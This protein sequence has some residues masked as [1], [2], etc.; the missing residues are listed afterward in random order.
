M[1]R[2]AVFVWILVIVGIFAF[3]SLFA[4][5]VAD[6]INY[7]AVLLDADG[8]AMAGSKAL[9]RISMLSPEDGKQVY[10]SELHDIKTDESGQFNLVIGTG[11]PLIGKLSAV[12][13]ENRAVWLDVE[14]EDK[15]SRQFRHLGNS[16]LLAVPYA[17]Y[18]NTAGR[19]ETVSSAPEKQQSIFWVTTGNSLTKP[20]FHFIGTRDAQDLVIKTNNIE[21]VRITK[22]GQFKVTGGVAG[23]SDKEGDYPLQVSGSLQGIHIKVNGSRSTVNNFMTFGDD[24]SH[25]W[26]A[27]EGQTRPELLAYRSYTDAVAAYI[28]AG[29]NLGVRIGAYTAMSLAN[30]AEAPCGS[31]MAAPKALS[32]TALATELGGLLAESIEWATKTQSEAGV[33]YHSGFADYAEWLP[34]DGNEVAFQPGEIVGVKGGIASKRTDNEASHF[35]VVSHNPILLGNMPDEAARDRFEKISFMGQVPVKVVG[36]VNKGDFILPS[37]N[38][39][40]LGIAVHPSKMK[41]GDYARIVGVA[42]EAA[43][44]GPMY[45]YVNTAV[46]I[47]SYYMS[48]RAELLNRRI[49]NIMDYL[50]GKAPLMGME[51][52][53]MVATSLSQAAHK[54]RLEKLV[55]DEVVDQLLER[56]A[57]IVHKMY[58][59]MEEQMIKNGIDLSA[60]PLILAFKSDPVGMLKEMRRNPSFLTQWAVLDQKLPANFK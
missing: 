12:P 13:F 1:V 20:P 3:G 42:W 46:G 26:G 34:L 58:G 22:L 38:N 60:N 10:F 28:F 56:N 24:L 6:G 55:A 9:L 32:A 47:N 17:K 27:I 52:L 37:G 53:Q 57:S 19:L 35:L 18:A 23:E 51:E 2:S 48:R 45:N 54:T 21:R 59:L 30:A 29:A 40:G 14:I 43:T 11:R 39:D 41:T 7:Q 16:R 5:P 50:E 31:P 33:L 15:R 49:E 25:S 4:Q 36:S 44:E 8:G